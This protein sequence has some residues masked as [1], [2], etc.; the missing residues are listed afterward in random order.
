MYYMWV[1]RKGTEFIGNK[2]THSLTYSALYTVFQ[3][4]N[5]P[6]LNRPKLQQMLT[7]FQ[8]SFT[9]RLSN[10]PAMKESLNDPPHLK[11]VATL[12]CEM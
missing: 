11:R 7:D 8:I 12:P 5:N 1:G 4:K 6:V 3:K 2:F 10:K 9:I